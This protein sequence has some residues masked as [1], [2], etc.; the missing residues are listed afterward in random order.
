M[1]IDEEIA[2]YLSTG[3]H[4]MTLA[5]WP[6]GWFKNR[7]AE[8][9][10][11]A[12]VA[13]VQRRTPGVDVSHQVPDDLAAFTRRRIEAMVHGLFPRAEWPTV[14][15]VLERSVVFLTPGFQRVRR[16]KHTALPC[17]QCMAA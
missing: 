14:R 6:G 15:S 16:R 10:K 5:A 1:G 4:D 9:L 17:R 12:L 7:G 13:E 2:R 8:D 11:A 3:D